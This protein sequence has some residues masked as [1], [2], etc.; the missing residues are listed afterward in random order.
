MRTT[1]RRAMYPRS[2]PN[3][4]SPCSWVPAFAG[5]TK[6]KKEIEALRRSFEGAQRADRAGGVGEGGEVE[7][8]DL[9]VVGLGRQ[10]Q[11]GRGAGVEHQRQARRHAKGRFLRVERRLKGRGEAHQLVG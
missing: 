10:R 11:F 3:G 9:V 5:M 7:L 8:L 1:F 2:L 6:S 4:E